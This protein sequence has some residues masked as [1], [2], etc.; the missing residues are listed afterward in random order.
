MIFLSIKINR[1]N[2]KQSLNVDDNSDDIYY[3]WLINQTSSVILKKRTEYPVTYSTCISNKINAGY[4]KENDIDTDDEFLNISLDNKSFKITRDNYSTLPLF[5]SYVDDILVISN[6]FSYVVS[7]TTDL[8]IN[9]SSLLKSLM[10]EENGNNTLYKEIKILSEHQ[11][12]VLDKDNFQLINSPAL[13]P[14]HRLTSNPALFTETLEAKLMDFY[15]TRLKGQKIATE[16]SGGINSAVMPLFLSDKNL[17]NPIIASIVYDNF[18][19]NSQNEK[20][21]LI[22]KITNT[23][24]I[25]HKLNVAK[26]YPLVQ[27]AK[28]SDNFFSFSE[29]CTKPLEDLA[30]NLAILGVKVVTTGVGGNKLFEDS[31]KSDLISKDNKE[32]LEEDNNSILPPFLT[33]TFLNDYLDSSNIEPSSSFLTNSNIARNNIYIDNGIWPVSPFYNLELINYCQNLPEES[34][35]EKNI[36]R[37]Y[38]QSKR[39]PEE[40]SNPLI[41]ENINDFFERSISSNYFEKI[42]YKYLN[43]SVVAKL[44]YV[45]IDLLLKYY[46][47]LKNSQ[48]LSKQWLYNIFILITIEINLANIKITKK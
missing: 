26:D 16:V 33:S 36:L 47:N 43:N 11:S 37:T 24:R 4:G 15:N 8:T 42:I 41:D 20:I 7:N 10:L 9:Q 44:G 29:V 39:W 34:K 21:A 17:E 40:I 5:Y 45:N 19:N 3:Q 2:F 12:I 46:L 27:C 22:Q 6:D 30:K 28:Q 14:I 48:T 32:E 1:N 13:D 23:K 31:T 18:Y 25:E 38:F 35:S